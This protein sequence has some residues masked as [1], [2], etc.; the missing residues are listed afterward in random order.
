MDR[1]GWYVWGVFLIVLILFA[2]RYIHRFRESETGFEAHH[3]V[4]VVES[5]ETGIKIYLKAKEWGITGNHNLITISLSPN[6]VV[7]TN[8]GTD[9]I[10]EGQRKIFYS[11][12]N[13]SLIV[14]HY[15][16]CIAPK[17]F[18]SSINIRC[19]EINHPSFE[20][21]TAIRNDSILEFGIDYEK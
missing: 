5:K 9:Y 6:L 16:R 18:D 13:D 10:F 21:S 14:Y 3:N 12:R 1:I 7:N 19:I 4:E 20:L 8:L 11:F 17:V 2:V 15:G